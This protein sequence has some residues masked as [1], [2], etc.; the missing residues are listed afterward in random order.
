MRGERCRAGGRRR[1]RVWCAAAADLLPQALKASSFRD[2]QI[3]FARSLAFPWINYPR[4]TVIM[5]LPLAARGADRSCGAGCAA[6]AIE[7][8]TLAMG[9]WVVLQCAAMA[10]SRGANGAAPA[11]RYLD[12]VALGYLAN[13]AA[14]LSWLNP[15]TSRRRV[16]RVRRRHSWRGFR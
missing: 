14:I 16:A 5:W 15:R 13:T 9:A 6:T 11:S 10:Y 8:V 4:A 3:A 1:C 12:M 2:F 7:Q